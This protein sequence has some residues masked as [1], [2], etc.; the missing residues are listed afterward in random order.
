M[1]LT[2]VGQILFGALILHQAFVVAML[3]AR[4]EPRKDHSI[5]MAVFFLVN[6]LT[7]VPLG[8]QTFGGWTDSG[9]AIAGVLVAPFIMLQGPC[10]YFYVLAL[11]SPAVV[12]LG[13]R[14]W[15]HLAGFL[16]Y[17]VLT[18]GAALLTNQM[19]MPDIGAHPD[20]GVVIHKNAMSG[21][22]AYF[23]LSW[24][25]TVVVIANLSA[26]SLFILVTSFYFV[27]VIRLLLRYRRSKF[28]YFSSI[29]GRSL[30]WFEWIIGV[31]SVI[32][33]ANI[34][35]IGDNLFLR[36]VMSSEDAEMLVET[37]W[38]L[39]LSFMVLWQPAI[40]EP[41]RPGSAAIEDI[42]PELAGVAPS[43]YQRSALD[44]ERCLRIIGKI[45]RA[46][47]EDRL[48]RSQNVT[49]RNLSDHTRVSENYLSQV[50]N[51]YLERN[52]YDYIN[53]WRIKDACHLLH[54]SKTS[55]IDIGEEVGFNSRSTFNAAFKK[56]TGQTPS[57]YRSATRNAAW[58]QDPRADVTSP[59][60]GAR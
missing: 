22:M 37:A 57:E 7:S 53:H 46:M 56:E 10:V 55:I 45:E 26:L 32:W 20:D 9:V 36:S 38:V 28:D 5:A 31:L 27:L 17:L 8:G 1:K 4:P 35:L 24:I 3:L 49:L 43:K 21:L 39:I 25:N 30:T 16:I 54:Q 19:T 48:Y 59:P 18:V 52:F 15:R 58:G 50:L 23:G 41:K 60:A 13:R 14:D 47:T 11:I 44:Q 40:F 42:P 33:I 51:E 6:M 29:E 12:K 34:L 2:L